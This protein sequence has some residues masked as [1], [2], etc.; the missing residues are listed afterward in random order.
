LWIDAQNLFNRYSILENAIDAIIG[1]EKA[2]GMLAAFWGNETIPHALVFSGLSG[3]GKMAAATAFAMACNCSGTRPGPADKT[4]LPV[5]GRCPACHKIKS[6]NHPDIL[7]LKPAGDMIKVKQIR[8]LLG[9]MALKPFEASTRVVILQDAHTLNPSAGNALLKALE[10][11]PGDTLFILT[12]EERSSLMPTIISR[13]QHVRFRPVDRTLITGALMD[14]R[15]ISTPEATLAA[16]LSGGSLTRAQQ[17]L[18]SDWMQYRQWLLREAAALTAASPGILLALAAVLANRKERITDAVALLKSWFRD[19]LVCKHA[20]D[21]LINQ[22]MQDLVQT[23]AQKET[24]ESL[25]KKLTALDTVSRRFAGNANVR[26]CLEA[27]LLKLAR[28]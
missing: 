12:T 20:P 10:E 21:R 15:G 16:H 25:L 14:T 11:P 19:L 18:D 28:T 23:A 3:T 8:E 6:A 5:C 22:D 13:C 4:A 24:S 7:H 9:T 17:I 27:L 1:Q 26:L 2:L